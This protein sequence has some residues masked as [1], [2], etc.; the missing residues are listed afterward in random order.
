MTVLGTKNAVK[1]AIMVIEMLR[2]RHPARL[3]GLTA[4]HSQTAARPLGIHATE[5]I[6]RPPPPPPAPL[7]VESHRDLIQAAVREH[8]VTFVHG[9]TGCGKS[10][11][12]PLLLLDELTSSGDRK[13]R[14]FCSQPVRV[15]ARGLYE[16]LTRQGH[17]VGLR[18]GGQ[19]REGEGRRTRLTFCTTGYLTA[20]IAGEM[21]ER[22]ET[23]IGCAS[24]ARGGRTSVDNAV[25]PAEGEPLSDVSILVIDE[26]HNRAIEA[27]VLC[28]LCRRIMASHRKLRLVLMSATAQF[29]ELRAYFAATLGAE[30]ISPTLHVG[31]RRFSRSI[32]YLGEL[33]SIPG[34]A[35]EHSIRLVREQEDALA[36]SLVQCSPQKRGVPTGAIS[37]QVVLAGTLAPLA[38]QQA[39]REGGEGAVLI[40]VAGVSDIQELMVEL[41]ARPECVCVPL[42]GEMEMEEQLEAF[43]P[44]RPPL[45]KVVVATNAAESSLTLPDVDVV[46]DTGQHKVL[47][48]GEGGGGSAAGPTLERRWISKASAEQ[49]A[50]RTGRMRPG[51][52]YRL[53]PR[54]WAAGE[55]DV[56]AKGGSM[57]LLD[58]EPCDLQTQ[59]LDGAVLKLRA[60]LDDGADVRDLLGEMLDAPPPASVERAVSSLGGLGMLSHLDEG[61]RLTALGSFGAGLPLEPRHARML[62]MAVALGV[63]GE[64]CSL[65]AVLSM[66]RSLFKDVRR[67]MSKLDADG[68]NALRRKVFESAVRLDGGWY[69]EPL[70]HLVLHAEYEETLVRPSSAPLKQLR[71][72]RPIRKAW[73]DPWA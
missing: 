17:A 70:Q 29:D 36:R 33:T 11:G 45:V 8:R 44:V 59:P 51:A 22:A 50:G 30:H 63:A 60:T 66:Q 2:S 43:R 5:G 52:V 41:S 54:A 38:A 13:G 65:A 26:C 56:E 12:V 40:F 28:L 27:D 48:H 18:L 37:Q 1:R 31:S 68:C 20:K 42:H 14:V 62:A 25:A 71:G 49:R 67:G 9:E 34:A 19:V 4:E 24:K 47:S 3:G 21:R 57:R 39:R 16:H 32:H 6:R 7:P 23:G 73:C 64:G 35:S 58:H 15:A 61:G 53:Y 10:S 55:A 46:L 69:C 72:R